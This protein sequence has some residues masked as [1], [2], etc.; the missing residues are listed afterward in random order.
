MTLEIQLNEI[1]IGR[2]GFTAA[3]FYPNWQNKQL[4]LTEFPEI[5]LEWQLDPDSMKGTCVLKEKVF[6][7]DL[8]PFLGVIG[9]PPEETGIHSTFPPRYCGG[10]LDCKELV[11]GSTLYLPISVDGAYLALGDG[12]AAQGDGEVSCQAIECPMELVD[13]TVKLNKE[14]KLK[15]PRANK[16]SGWITFGLHEELNE[17]TVQALDGMLD[18]IGELYGLDRVQ[19]IA[20]GS[21]VIDLRITQIVNGVKGVHA[22]LPHNAITIK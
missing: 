19:A 22:C 7:V 10:N 15:N 5:I 14:L 4:K 9:M 2:Y 6:A 8:N 18:L 1:Q 17:A 12:H 13:V 16:P 11:A 21:S 3:G 20:I